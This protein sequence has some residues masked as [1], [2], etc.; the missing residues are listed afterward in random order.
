MEHIKTYIITAALIRRGD[1]ILL[2]RQQGPDD[3]CPYWA[4]PGGL[5]EPGE[6][7][8]DALVREVREE[9]GLDVQ[10]V[11]C[12]LY[13]THTIDSEHNA[14]SLAYVLDVPSWQGELHP[15]DPDGHI[16]EA[17]FVPQAEAITRLEQLPWQAM[18]APIITYLRG[19][20]PAGAMWLYKETGSQQEMISV[21]TPTPIA[22]QATI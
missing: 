22:E 14:Q 2:V 17:A 10:Q 9:T 8:T 4:L 5:V 12:L 21:L 11:G 19:A 3:P 13:A 1:A 16:L 15:D 6:L 7:I 20:H 18:S